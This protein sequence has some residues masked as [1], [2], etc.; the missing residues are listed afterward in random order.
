[1]NEETRVVFRTYSDGE[2]IALF[3]DE[4]WD[5]NYFCNS[6]M[7]IGQH[8]PADY[9]EVVQ[10]TRLSTPEEYK[11]LKEELENY[12]DTD[13]HYNLKIIQRWTPKR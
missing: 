9:R 7:H 8:G 11:D 12:G 6:Y 2:V 5:R 10:D 1:M 13:S 3:P 4:K